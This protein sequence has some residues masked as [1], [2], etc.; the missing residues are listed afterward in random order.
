MS[1]QLITKKQADQVVAALEAW[2]ATPEQK[3]LEDL[4]DA[5]ERPVAR[6][7]QAG[8]TYEDVAQE[9]IQ[10]GISVDGVAIATY[11]KPRKGRRSKRKTQ[12]LQAQLE[13]VIAQDIFDQAVAHI[14]ET[15]KQKRGL[16]RAEFVAANF[17]VIELCL[18]AGKNY[19]KIASFLDTQQGIK[20]APST[21][22]KYHR[23]AKQKLVEAESTQPH[24]G[25][26]LVTAEP[27]LA[28][29]LPEDPVELSE[30]NL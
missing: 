11:L 2:S 24:I 4:L 8:V 19:L 30:F 15:S 23:Q 13:Q 22:A 20:I 1:Q 10:L 5:I 26:T 12:S 28:A 3:C 7:V 6:M 16:T 18:A 17:Q 21:L 29:K 27:S 9:L 25:Q 14:K